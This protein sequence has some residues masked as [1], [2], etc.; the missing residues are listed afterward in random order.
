MFISAVI[1]EN[2]SITTASNQALTC[3]ISGLSQDTPVTWIDP[4]NEEI[5]ESDSENYVIDQGE[6][7][8]GSKSSTLTI[9]AAK[10]SSLSTGDL[11]KCKV[12]SALYPTY[13]PDIVKEMVLTLLAFGTV[14]F[15]LKFVFSVK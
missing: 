4:D 14:I 10:I 2:K 1:F 5:S 15:I 9:A 6:Y 7:D 11:F 3:T 8:S 12:R 13:S